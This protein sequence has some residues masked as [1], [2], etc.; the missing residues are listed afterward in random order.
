MLKP[1]SPSS[2]IVVSAKMRS[3]RPTVVFSL[4]SMP[5][6]QDSSMSLEL[7][8]LLLVLLRCESLK[9]SSSSSSELSIVVVVVSDI[10]A[11]KL[12]LLVVV[13]SQVCSLTGS[14]DRFAVVMLFVVLSSSNSFA[15]VRLLAEYL[16]VNVGFRRS[17]NPIAAAALRGS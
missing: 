1:P 7:L 16:S 13:L 3:T 5:N 12:L 9:S 4:Q 11:S 6:K 17:K 8:A 2:R 14:V 15:D 10:I